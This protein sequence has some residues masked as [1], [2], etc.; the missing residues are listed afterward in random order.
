MIP[1]AA[2]MSQLTNMAPSK[3]VPAVDLSL[4]KNATEMP[5]RPQKKDESSH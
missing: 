2:R 4:K 1:N 3:P 5:P